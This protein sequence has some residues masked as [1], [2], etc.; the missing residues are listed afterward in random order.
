M[1]SLRQL[2]E[3]GFTND[4]LAQIKADRLP[5]I[6]G[7]GGLLT[8]LISEGGAAGGAALGTAFLPG[9]GTIAGAGLGALFG[10]LGENKIRDDEFKLGDALGEAAFS[11]GTAS[12]AP[13][14]RGVKGVKAA[15]AAGATDDLLGAFGS[16][17]SSAP[18]RGIAASKLADASDD[19][20]IRSFKFNRSQLQGIKKATGKDATEIAKKL[21]LTGKSVDDLQDQLLKLNKQFGDDVAKIG[22]ITVGDVRKAIVKE[23]DQYLQN[24]V[25]ELR[26][27]G[28]EI[29]EEGDAL[30]ANIGDDATKIGSTQWNSIKGDFDGLTN[31]KTIFN[32]PTLAGK[33]PVNKAIG[34]AIRETLRSKSGN[35][36]LK[37]LGLDIRDL[38]EFTEAAA[39]QSDLGRGTLA[40]GLTD[41]AAVTGGTATSGPVGGAAAL[42]GKRAVNSPRSQ[43]LLSQAL[44]G[45]SD[46][47]SRIPRTGFTTQLA[48][49]LAARAPGAAAAS[50]QSQPISNAATPMTSPID[51]QNNSSISGMIPEQ[52]A[53][54]QTL[55]ATGGLQDGGL[56]LMQELEMMR[57]ETLLEALN[58]G[59]DPEE[60]NMVFDLMLQSSGLSQL[61][62]QVGGGLNFADLN[63]DS[64]KRIVGLQNVASD[65]ENLESDM[66]SSGLFQDE[67]QL[68]ASIGGFYD[69]TIGRIAD[70]EKRA[71]IDQLRSRGISIIRALG[72]V[73]NLSE[74]EQAAAIANLPNVGDNLE[75]ATIKLDSLKERF[76]NARQNVIGL[77]TGQIPLGGF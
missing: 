22:D 48:G 28:Q 8:S 52:G 72:E 40:L 54:G 21:K 37:N 51:I 24:P 77:N 59:A 39:K 49:Q 42:L 1:A 35:N 71:F 10:R 60:V 62:P 19:A 58:Q 70:S 29:L 50:G 4:Q 14:F 55:G 53:N 12:I 9:L 18:A 15:K 34:G 38:T 63:A 6:S 74:T 13:I 31:W 61:L 56:G 66:A 20:S 27:V 73:G 44:G 65:L 75:T 36:A 45:A 2:E 7:R 69:S 57:A 76:E 30:L 26:R 33:Q 5:E 3:M 23:A 41:I 11:A 64:Q 32:N 43:A 68:A 47:A 25:P 67:S 17:F 16:G 46:L